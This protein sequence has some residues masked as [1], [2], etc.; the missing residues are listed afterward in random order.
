MSSCPPKQ[1]T[2]V[3]S[4]RLEAL[5][6][7]TVSF[8]FFASVMLYWRTGEDAEGQLTQSR[9][10]QFLPC[11]PCPTAGGPPPSPGDVYFVETSEQTKPSYLFMCF[12]ESE[13]RTHHGTR[14][15]VFMKGLANGNASLPNHWGFSLLSCFPNVEV[16][17]LHLLELFS[18]TPLA[19]WYLQAQQRWEPYF[20]PILSDAC[21][22]A[23][24]EIRWHLPGHSLHCA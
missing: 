6:I 14:V 8:V 3:L 17:P 21:R 18:G 11:L 24:M 15:M 9:C 23:I 4:H 13:A 7:L 12:V 22:I 19:K 2:M 5:F 20:L 10:A 1:T 16:R